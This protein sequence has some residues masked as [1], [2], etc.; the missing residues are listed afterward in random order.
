MDNIYIVAIDQN[1]P[2]QKRRVDTDTGAVLPHK[3]FFISN[4]KTGSNARIVFIAF[5]IEFFQGK[6]KFVELN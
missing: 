4:G 6:L 5:D 1:Y 2:S 3:I